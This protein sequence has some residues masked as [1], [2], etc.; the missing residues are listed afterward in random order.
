MLKVKKGVDDMAKLE[1]GYVQIYTG[2]GKGKTTAAFGLALRAAGNDMKVFI[3]QFIKGMKYCEI[4]A[5]EKLS[6]H[7]TVKQYGRGCFINK[8]PDGKDIRTAVSGFEELKKIVAS[9]NYD[10]VIL[11]EINIALHFHLISIDDVI[12]LIDSKPDEMELVI[13]GRKADKRLIDKAD[14]VTEMSEVKHYYKN[15]VLS[16]KGI[17]C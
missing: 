1:K 17:D 3:G 8:K 16:R 13:T 11:D 9:C 7:I 5:L 6:E 10:L 12:E 14:L 15:G 4:K 2:N